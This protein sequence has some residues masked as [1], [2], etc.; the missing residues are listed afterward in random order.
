ME[1]SNAAAGRHPG[2]RRLAALAFV[3]W[4]G[5]VCIDPGPYVPPPDATDE[6]TR[7]GGATC[8]PASQGCVFP[9]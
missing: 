9:P 3:L 2:C 6:W 1:T 5:C 7:A 4:P 8:D